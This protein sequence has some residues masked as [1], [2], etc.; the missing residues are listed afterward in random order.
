MDA[1]GDS[2]RLGN[3]RGKEFLSIMLCLFVVGVELT[4]REVVVVG[5]M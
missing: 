2:V 1:R 5:G 4:W 3:K